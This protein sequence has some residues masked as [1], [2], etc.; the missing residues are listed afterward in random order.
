M[1]TFLDVPIALG[2]SFLGQVVVVFDQQEW[3]RLSDTRCIMQ[4]L[5][6][7][8]LGERSHLLAVSFAMITA[9]RAGDCG[10]RV[11]ISMQ[12]A[13]CQKKIVIKL[14]N[15]WAVYMLADANTDDGH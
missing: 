2:Y 11:R 3:R 10:G 4:Y 9:F 15:P 6:L 13:R 12:A 8:L 14:Y 1:G 7:D 5:F